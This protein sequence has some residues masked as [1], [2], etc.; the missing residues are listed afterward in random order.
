[1]KTRFP[2]LALLCGVAALALAAP[3]DSGGE[4]NPPAPT[5][6]PLTDEQKA[7]AAPARERLETPE[8]KAVKAQ[9]K[10]DAAAAAK[11]EKSQAAAKPP[12]TLEAATATLSAP[13]AAKG[14]TVYRVKHQYADKNTGKVHDAGSLVSLDAKRHEQLKEDGGAGVVENDPAPEDAVDESEAA[15]ILRAQ[16]AEELLVDEAV[17]VGGG[18]EPGAPAVMTTSLVPAVLTGG[19]RSSAT[20]K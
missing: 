2:H 5:P 9:A 6:E 4:P 18:L 19:R 12:T 7:E 15:R 10:K 13:K 16:A 20:P 17:A 1:M 11:A 3:N 8:A 14:E